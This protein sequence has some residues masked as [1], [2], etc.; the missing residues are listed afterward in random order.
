MGFNDN[1]KKVT[2]ALLVGVETELDTEFSFTASMDE[3]ERLTKTLGFIPIGRVTQKR[4]QMATGT[5]FGKGKLEEIAA[6]TGG[7]GRVLGFN[8]AFDDDDAPSQSLDHASA[9]VG[10][11]NEQADVV[12]VDSELTPTQLSNLEDAFGCEVIDRTGVILEIFN[13]HAQSREARLQVEIARLAY[14]A[15]RLRASH[16]GGDRQGGGMGSKGAGESS[17]ELDRRRIRD[18]IAELKTQLKSIRVE[19]Q[20][21]QSRRQDVDLVALI[22]YTNAGKSSLMRRLTAADTAG[23]DKLFATLDTTVRIMQPETTPRVL[24]SDTVGFIKKLPH[25]LVASFRSTLD[26]AKSASLLLYVVDGSDSNFRSQLEVTQKVMSEIGADTNPSKLVINKVD[27]IDE[28]G[29]ARLKAEYPEALFISTQKARDIEKV[30][31]AISSFFEAD[32]TA[33]EVFIPYAKAGNISKIRSRSKIISETHSD[34]GTTIVYRAH[35]QAH[36]WIA[37]QLGKDS[38][39][40]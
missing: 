20:T 9:A 26:E 24:V 22:G 14:L 19:H 32:M 2:K 7:S 34:D 13:R 17:H 29:V 6:W 30:K 38:Q 8:Q 12:I 33:A 5:V 4:K 21:R 15:P 28:L 40:D 39:E 27:L 23:E 37:K 25:D 31:T 36:D 11:S 16:I 35:Q 18:R 3:L 1:S 10:N